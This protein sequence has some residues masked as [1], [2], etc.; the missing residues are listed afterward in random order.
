MKRY[1]NRVCQGYEL[2]PETYSPKERIRVISLDGSH[3]GNYIQIEIGSG[4]SSKILALNTQGAVELIC[5]IQAL[6][7]N[8]IPNIHGVVRED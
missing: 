5:A 3:S 6:M 4:E 8:H 1:E 2:N 7:T